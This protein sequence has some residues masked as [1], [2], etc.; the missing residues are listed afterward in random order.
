MQLANKRLLLLQCRGYGDAVITT[1]LIN[2]LGSSFPSLQIDVLTRAPFVSLFRKNPHVDAIYTA[3]FPTTRDFRWLGAAGLALRIA[4]L[5]GQKYDICLNTAGDFRENLMGWMVGPVQNRAIRWAEG[6]PYRNLI[7]PGLHHL[8]DHE[9]EIDHSILNVYDAHAQVAAN[10]GCTSIRG[11]HL[12]LDGGL[13]EK[14]RVTFKGRRVVAIHPLAGHRS[15]LWEIE[16]W[17]LFVSEISKLGYD[18]WIFCSQTDATQVE[19]SFAGIVNGDSVLI[20]A[21]SLEDFLVHLSVAKLLVGLDSFAVHVAHALGVPSIML[22]GASDPR[23]WAPPSTTVVSGD[24]ECQFYPCYNR[25]RCLGTPGEYICMKSI[26]HDRLLS[27]TRRLLEEGAESA[28]SKS[29]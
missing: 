19:K 12:Y 10:M 5:R 27:V 21:D 23:I 1:S 11:P 16:K 15:K 13:L 25:P 20:R 28:T 2:S 18:V 29:R 17:R 8:V 26:S 22:S 6:H 9:D 14:V 24:H 3:V 4:R 7:R